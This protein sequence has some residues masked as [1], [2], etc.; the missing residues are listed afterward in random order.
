MPILPS[1]HRIESL[2][3]LIFGLALSISALAL[4]A[5]PVS[6][7][8]ELVL[9]L[10]AFAFGF[11]VLMVVW[12]RYTGSMAYLAVETT[13]AMRLNVLLLFL[14][15]VEPYLF[16]QVFG[17]LNVGQVD[18]SLAA[19]ASQAYS[20]DLALLMGVL[21]SLEHLASK[22]ASINSGSDIGASFRHY[23]AIHLIAAGLFLV[24]VL[25]IFWT[26][27]VFG[28]PIRT[29]IWYVPLIVFALWRRLFGVWEQRRRKLPSHVAELVRRV[30]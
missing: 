19:V 29:L 6:T 25:P 18:P 1:K 12:I 20:F 16:N 23:R 30:P 21:A 17:P 7:P 8:R 22:S 5:R 15:A 14:V 27:M 24:S 28:Q 13:G 10:V 4:I 3:D 26:T 9:D 2:S 11:V